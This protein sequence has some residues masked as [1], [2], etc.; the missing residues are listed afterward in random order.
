MD[1]EQKLTDPQ[2]HT[3]SDNQ[4]A[5]VEHYAVT[6]GFQHSECDC[7]NLRYALAGSV[8]LDVAEP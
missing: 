7:V 5:P 6:I 4:F 2:P 1:S 3:H 8:H